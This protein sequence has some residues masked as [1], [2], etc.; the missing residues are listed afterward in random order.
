ML[1]SRI[2][3]SRAHQSKSLHKNISCQKFFGKSTTCNTNES[4]FNSTATTSRPI[5]SLSTIHDNSLVLLK[6]SSGTGIL[7][8]PRNDPLYR[9]DQV[10]FMGRKDGNK[11]FYAPRK[12]PRKK[13]KQYH[14]RKREEY[15]QKYGR[16]SKPGSKAGPR[17]E[18]QRLEWQNLVDL[19]S[20]KISRGV[21]PESLEYNYGDGR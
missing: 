17:R 3:T 16:H 14:R 11:A 2:I 12:T 13:L 18:R 21:K 10:R 15:H 20:G 5:Q 6:Y 7:P 9:L 8:R 19:G 1:S 4:V